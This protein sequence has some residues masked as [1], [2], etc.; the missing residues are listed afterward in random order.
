MIEIAYTG[1]FP[2]LCLGLLTVTIDGEPWEFP[3]D[4]L[5]SGGEIIRARRGRNEEDEVV[6]GPWEIRR[7]PPD[8]PDDPALRQHVRTMINRH[9][10]WGCCG[11][12]L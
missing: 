2:E 4:C 12:C 9:L 1:A 3:L 5:R 11:G 10:P 8:F 6:V 7:W